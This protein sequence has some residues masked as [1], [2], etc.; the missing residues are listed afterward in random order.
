VASGG[1]I[2]LLR[3]QFSPF[4]MANLR[5]S[6]S[7]WRCGPD[8][9]TPAQLKTAAVDA[10]ATRAWIE[11]TPVLVLHR[12]GVGIMEYFASIEAPV[13]S[14]ERQ[15]LPGEKLSGQR[16]AGPRAPGGYTPEEAIALVRLG[17]QTQLLSMNQAWRDLI[18]A[19]AASWHFH[20]V[21][22]LG[23]D[24]YL[25]VGGLRDLSQV[26]SARLCQAHRERTE[27]RRRRR[28]PVV[29]IRP[30]RPTGSTTVV[31]IDIDPA[32]GEDLQGY[33]DEHAVT[34]RGIGAMDSFYH[35]RARR[36]VERELSEDLSTDAE[37]AVYLLGN[38][39]LILFNNSLPQV[40]RDTRRRMGF[41][42]TDLAMTYIY[43]HYA[44]L[45][46][47]VYL[48]EAILRMYIQRL[49]TLAATSPLRRKEMIGALHGA[50]ADLV[51]YQEN[52]TPYATRIEFLE[53]A[54]AY[55]KLDELGERFERKQDL[56]LT[57]SQEYND[58]REVRAAEFLNYLAAI[59]AGG[60]LGNLV[61]N[62]FGL[63]PDR[64][65]GLYLGVTLGSIG[66]AFGV[67]LLLRVLL[68]R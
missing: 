13:S 40:L 67:M 43:M 2:D 29:E 31:L 66:L 41:S 21:T 15:T 61:V 37:S 56:L 9:L 42:S 1:H 63:P 34:L 7:R 51:Q 68:R 14:A 38:S 10:D 54:R 30:P 23:P 64:F 39:E 36:I 32:P 45:L 53:R 48:Q 47:W 62:A 11:V 5:P 60:E 28:Q 22:G 26:I 55:H 35:E 50:L 20:S 59:L 46:E 16:V 57:Y 49:D 58:F 65:P 17:I 44:T 3:V 52:I 33:V 18:P 24:Q 6:L 4:Q 8:R 12:A 27:H 19:D 25:A